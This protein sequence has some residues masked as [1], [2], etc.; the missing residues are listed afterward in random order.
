MSRN[1]AADS[2]L[3]L[4]GAHVAFIG[5]DLQITLRFSNNC[6]V[7]LESAFAISGAGDS[8]TIIDP[9]GDKA[10]FVPVLKLHGELVEAAHIN[11]NQLVLK[12]SNE[13]VLVAGPDEDYESWSYTGPESTPT[14]VIAMPGGELAIWQS[15]ED[16]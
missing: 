1:T 6:V 3:P 5:V 15:D 9:G 4:V 7:R 2:Q 11:D 10:R 14:R 12:F 16:V 8:Q 13:S